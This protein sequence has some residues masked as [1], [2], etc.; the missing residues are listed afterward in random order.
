MG[1]IELMVGY[2]FLL[3]KLKHKNKPNNFIN[4]QSNILHT[5]MQ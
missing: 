4:K 2:H 5:I 3:A 1:D